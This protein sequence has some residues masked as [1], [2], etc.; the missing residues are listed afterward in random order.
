MEKK[1]LILCDLDDTIFRTDDFLR[2]VLVALS[3]LDHG[4]LAD[5][6]R[7]DIAKLRAKSGTSAGYPLDE[8]IAPFAEPLTEILKGGNNKMIFPDARDF[9]QKLPDDAQFFIFTRGE[10]IYQNLKLTG[11]ILADAEEYPREIFPEQDKIARFLDEITVGEGGFTF[12]GNFYK[13]VV[14]VDNDGCYFTGFA[15]LGRAGINACGFLVHH[16]NPR[17]ILPPDD[18]LPTGVKSVADFSQVEI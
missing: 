10:E 8:K 2:R 5:K 6:I 9:V 15:R 1:T 7:Q 11:T 3:E 18:E 13:E 4:D 14:F 12:Q 17:F 16:Q